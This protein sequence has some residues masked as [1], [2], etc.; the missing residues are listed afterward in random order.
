MMEL[1]WWAFLVVFA[2]AALCGEF[3]WKRLR[4]EPAIVYI[5]QGSFRYAGE[6]R[7]EL[8][9]EEVARLAA[10]TSQVTISPEASAPAKGRRGRKDK[11]AAAT[12]SQVPQLDVPDGATRRR[13]GRRR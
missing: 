12:S 5:R 4:K 9:A 2:V 3:T 13:L 6:A 1:G 11:R 7:Y 8:P 10:L